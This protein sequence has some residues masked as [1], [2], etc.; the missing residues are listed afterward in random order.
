MVSS[1]TLKNLTNAAKPFT[2][3]SVVS[4]WTAVSSDVQDMKNAPTTILH[5]VSSIR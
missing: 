5:D 3:S 2:Y 4:Q 1:V